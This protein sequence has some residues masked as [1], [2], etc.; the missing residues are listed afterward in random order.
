VPFSLLAAKGA[1]IAS[2]SQH[3]DANQHDK[4][5]QEAAAGEQRACF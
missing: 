4:G 3:F 2:V 5:Q 1:A